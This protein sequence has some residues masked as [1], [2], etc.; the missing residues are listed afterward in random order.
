MHHRERTP[1][2]NGDLKAAGRDG[3]HFLSRWEAEIGHGGDKLGVSPP[4]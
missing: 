4:S 2:C 3:V 1:R